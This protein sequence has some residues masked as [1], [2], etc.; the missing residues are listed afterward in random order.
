MELIETVLCYCFGLTNIFLILYLLIY[1]TQK[2]KAYPYSKSSPYCSILF[3]GCIFLHQ[4]LY[5]F[6]SWSVYRDDLALQKL[7]K[8]INSINTHC[9]FIIPIAFRMNVL[10]K[11][12]KYNFYHLT[13]Q[14]YNKQFSHQESDVYFNS[15]L[16]QP[17]QD[18]FFFLYGSLWFITANII[19]GFLLS[20]K[21]TRC[22]LYNSSSFTND[23]FIS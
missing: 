14:S 1:L 20:Y 18:F 16:S 10:E 7:L 23:N 19:L 15:R 4:L 3:V 2:R 12:A 17:N 13:Y 8:T 9:L 5:F 6:M 21:T 11:I 22:F